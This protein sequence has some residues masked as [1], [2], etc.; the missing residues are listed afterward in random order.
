MKEIKNNCPFCGYKAE[1]YHG[2]HNDYIDVNCTHCGYYR[3]SEWAIQSSEFYKHKDQAPVLSF[4]IRQNQ[5]KNELYLDSNLIK[6]ILTIKL[7]S[8]PEQSNNLIK[9]IGESVKKPDE[10]YIEEYHIVATRIG[11]ID[12]GGVKYIVKHLENSGIIKCIYE[13]GGRLQAYLTFNGWEE[14]EKLK[15]QSKIVQTQEFNFKKHKL[16]QDEKLWLKELYNNDF[17]KIELRE[18]RVKLNKKISSDFKPT[19]VDTRL[20]NFGR[21]TLLG[22]WYVDPENY[23]IQMTD[24]V[25]KKIQEIIN[26]NPK[27]DSIDS[28]TISSLLNITERDS[29][30]ALTFIV[31]LRYSNGS[32][33]SPDDDL[34]KRITFGHEATAFDNILNYKNIEG[35]L[36]NYYNLLAPRNFSHATQ[37]K[38]QKPK[39]RNKSKL[40]QEIW[41]QI[42]EEYG[43]NQKVFGKKIKFVDKTI[44]KIIFR[45]IEDAYTLYKK[46]FP[47]PAIILAG[48]VLEE[49]LRSYLAHNNQVPSKKTFDEYIKICEQ[50]KYLQLA[51]SRLVDSARY[52]RNLVHV[53]KE[54]NSRTSPTQSMAST[55]VSAIFT[56]I[57]DF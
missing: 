55:I 37:N 46:G 12:T 18:L 30:I 9:L 10:F 48:G 25:I 36:E 43:V 2:P 29:K 41:K 1:I 20:V 3:S 42:T 44:K 23:L 14:Y 54:F 51:A 27:L 15:Q 47:K 21:L 39:I 19:E 17:N 57:N 13:S 31:D 26:Q 56:I 16:S 4:W 32:N 49:L 33:Q 6:N 28:G 52:Y 34:F 22:L 5:N 40:N 50:K 38:S 7:P 45:D 24:L 35:A 53:E 8:P 11:A